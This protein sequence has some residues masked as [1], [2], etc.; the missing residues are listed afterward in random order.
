ML[1]RPL[2]PLPN[3]I[4]EAIQLQQIAYEFRQEV[5]YR[6]DFE[7]Y[8][9]WYYATAAQHQEELAA[10]KN[11]IPLFSWFCRSKA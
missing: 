10:M 9:Q 3:D 5:Q 11:D 1:Q 8:C 4:G 6:D 2:E 7:A